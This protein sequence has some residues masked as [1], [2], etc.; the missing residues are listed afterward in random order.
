MPPQIK[1]VYQQLYFRFW[2]AEKLPEMDVALIGKGSIDA[3]VK[4]ELFKKKLKTPVFTMKNENVDWFHEFLIP[5]KTPIMGGKIVMSVWDEDKVSDEIVGSI[6]FNAKELIGPKN[7]LF[8]W[9]NVYGSPLGVSGDN[10]KLMNANPE[11]AS[12]WKGRILM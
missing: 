4:Y 11:A 5:Q 3:Y 9:K 2:K 10:V 7:G 1:P 12:T 6:H 8:F